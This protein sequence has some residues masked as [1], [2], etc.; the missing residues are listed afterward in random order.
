MDNKD[1]DRKV[2]SIL[3]QEPSG[4]RFEKSHQIVPPTGGRR[5]EIGQVFIF[6]MD[7]RES[8][9]LNNK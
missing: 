7:A 3:P 6:Q 4:G 2:V 9:I 5:G 8:A 1:K